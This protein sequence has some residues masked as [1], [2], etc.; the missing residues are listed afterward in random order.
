MVAN[1]SQETYIKAYRFA[2]EAHLGQLF[3]G[4]DLPYMI[5]VSFVCMEVMAALIVQKEMDG[6]LAI[7]CALLHDVIEDT[8]KCFEDIEESFG[9]QVA[10]GVKALTKNKN[11]EKEKQLADSLIR[12]R[13]QPYEIWMVKLADRIS[14]LQPPPADWTK[15]EIR[16]YHADAREIH[17]ALKDSNAYLAARLE[18][19]ITNY[20]GYFNRGTDG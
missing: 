4:T 1:W 3:P 2:S 18:E 15:E 20:A 10:T 12:I 9:M 14:N 16:K 13:E 17:E 11:M 7:Q 6:D 8:K 5:H 19:K